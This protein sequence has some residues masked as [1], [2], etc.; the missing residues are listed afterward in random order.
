PANIKITPGGAVKVLDF[1]LAKVFAGGT[2]GADL[3]QMTAGT[4]DGMILGTPAYMSPEQARGQ[5]LDKRTDIWA[6]GVVLYEMLSGRR[7]FPGDTIP[8][9]I[10]AVLGRDPDWDAL[11]A[12][13]PASILRLLRRCLDKDP[14]MRVRDIGDARIE[15]V[16]IQQALADPTGRTASAVAAVPVP[17]QKLY[18]ILPWAAAIMILG[19]LA[20]WLIK[21]QPP[22]EPRPVVRFNYEVPEGQTVRFS[23][24]AAVMAFS[25]DGRGFVYNTTRGFYVR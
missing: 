14:K 2:G 3:S 4:R 11:P 16:E 15:I 6:F 7:A 22:P 19:A 9:T 21:P 5:T 24:G 12:A 10:A 20:G 8:D 17:K 25:P 23:A 1:G 18:R 13:I